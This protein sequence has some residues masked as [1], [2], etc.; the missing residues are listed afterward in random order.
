[1]KYGLLRLG[2]IV[3]ADH[4]DAGEKSFVEYVSDRKK[5]VMSNFDGGQM[6]FSFLIGDKTLMWNAHLGCYPGVLQQITPK[7]GELPRYSSASFIR[8]ACEDTTAD[9]AVDA[10]ILAIAGRANFNG[11]PF[12]GS[13]AE[14]A[15]MI[16]KWLGEP[17]EVI[18]CLHDESPIKPWRI[19]TR[20]AKAMVEKETKSRIVDLQPT[21]PFEIFT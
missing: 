17:K 21:K 12:D 2:E 11:R 5:N 6:T 19:D 4:L 16:C 7:P 14:A 15:T 1:M 3:P 9:E 8:K 10:L 18:W 20:A 13:G